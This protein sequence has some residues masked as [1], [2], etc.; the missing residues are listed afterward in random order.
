MYRACPKCGHVRGAHESSPPDR[1]PACGVYYGEWMKQRYRSARRPASRDDSASEIGFWSRCK[2]IA[3]TPHDDGRAEWS[4]R[5][6]VW[7][8]LAWLGWLSA[9]TRYDDVVNHTLSGAVAFMHR[10]DLV[11][12]EA[13]HVIFRLLGDFM[14]V[15]GGSL[16]QLIIPVAVFLV[17]LL[18]RGNPFGASVGLW[19][20]GQSLTDLAP[21][22]A[23]ARALRLPMLGGGTGADRPGFHDWQNILERLG[24]LSYDRVLGGIADSVGIA[25]MAL[26]LIW[27][28]ALLIQ[29]HRRLGGS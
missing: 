25:L 8:M 27:G 15:L 4:G 13:G 21:Y 18:K 1:C 20:S 12:H 11:F 28:A 7:A 5:L 23:D 3:L 29:Q 17:F 6:A 22:I 19:W 14:T 2:A 9:W 24:L 26:A 10:I 16:M